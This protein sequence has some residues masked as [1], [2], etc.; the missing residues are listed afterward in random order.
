MDGYIKKLRS[1]VGHD[2]IILN[3][4]A[5][6]IVNS[7]GKILL[8]K[9]GDE[10]NRGKWGLPGGAWEEGESAETAIKREVK[11]ETGLDVEVSKLIG[12]YSKYFSTYSNGDVSQTAVCLFECRPLSEELFADGIETLSLQYFDKEN[13]PEMFNEQH[14]DMIRDWTTGLSGIYR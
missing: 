1:K 8:Q 2:M 7:D 13:L 6:C 10:G 5:A 11:E 12:V 4:S 3:F 9:R 14:S